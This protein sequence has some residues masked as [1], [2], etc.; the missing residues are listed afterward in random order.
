MRQQTA[1]GDTAAVSEAA[2]TAGIPDDN[3][4]SAVN[5]PR[6]A[7]TWLDTGF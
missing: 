4:L 6:M 1:V 7:R 5:A 2:S 3:A